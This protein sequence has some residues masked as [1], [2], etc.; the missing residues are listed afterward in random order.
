MGAG[1]FERMK[2]TAY[3]IN[4]ARG[5]VVDEAALLEALHRKQIAGAGLDV[6]EHEPALTPGLEQLTNVTLLPHVG[7]A[8]DNT[9]RRMGAMAVENLIAGLEGRT[10]PNLINPISDKTT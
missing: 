9:R 6:Y 7:S 2:A 3:L 5:P 4:T 10:P 8:T 1:D